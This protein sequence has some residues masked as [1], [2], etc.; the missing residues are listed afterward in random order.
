[1]I[2]ESMMEKTLAILKAMVDGNTVIGDVMEIKGASVIPVSKI[3]VGMVS[4]GGEYGK[5]EEYLYPNAGL[6]GVGASLAPV[7][8]LYIGERDAKF[9]S[10]E[11]GEENKW[12][13]LISAT[14]NLLSSK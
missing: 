9:I 11:K 4:G 13:D 6:G 8:F 10:T 12:K 3:S 5:K 1:M 7:G 14:V 2:N